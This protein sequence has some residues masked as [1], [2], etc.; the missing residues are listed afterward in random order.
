[1]GDTAEGR[2]EFIADKSG[3][4]NSIWVFT[5]FNF[6]ENC[7]FELHFNEVYLMFAVRNEL[8]LFLE[9]TA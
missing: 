7:V 2:R 9:V 3:D 8:H 4:D 1:M 6:D 5:A